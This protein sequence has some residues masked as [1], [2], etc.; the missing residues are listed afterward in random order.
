[1]ALGNLL[2]FM[3]SLADELDRGTIDLKLG[4]AAYTELMIWL[5]GHVAVQDLEGVPS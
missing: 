3:Q 5:D 1:M 2:I 4:V